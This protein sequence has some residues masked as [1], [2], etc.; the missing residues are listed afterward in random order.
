MK[1]IILFLIIGIL[2]CAK[3]FEVSAGIPI[4]TT[5]VKII[6]IDTMTIGEEKILKVH[7]RDKK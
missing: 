4:D 6:K 5:T 3:T 1:I 2:S 7:Y